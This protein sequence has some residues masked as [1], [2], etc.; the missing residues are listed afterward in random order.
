MPQPGCI[1]RRHARTDRA[2]LTAA[3]DLVP[4]LAPVPRSADDG[5]GIRAEERF[6]QLLLLRAG[7][8]ASTGG[9]SLAEHSSKLGNP[10]PVR[11]RHCVDTR[12]GGGTRCVRVA[13]RYTHLGVSARPFHR[14]NQ[15]ERPNAKRQMFTA[16][17]RAS[18]RA[19]A[20]RARDNYSLYPRGGPPAL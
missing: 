19:G 17:P 4:E 8:G 18:G 20:A 14:A 2:R 12:R 15:Y 3:E 10:A 7:A 11:W 5:E 9:R 13:A 6:H 1:P 16:A